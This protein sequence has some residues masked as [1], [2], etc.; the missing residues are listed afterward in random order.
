MED[1]MRAIILRSVPVV[2][3]LAVAAVAS[4]VTLTLEST[5]NG[6]VVGPN[7]PIDWT[8]KA[9]VS[10]GDNSGLA[11]ISVGLSQDPNNPVKFD[12]PPATGVPAGMTNFAR[13]A[14]ISNPGSA[15]PDFG[16]RGDQRGTTGAKNLVQIGGGQNTFG[17]A[18]SS[19]GTS[20]TVAQGVGQSAPQIIASGTFN[21]PATA[22]VYKYYLDSGL[23]NTLNAITPP[24]P[25][26]FWPVSAA[27]VV[28]PP[29]AA[30]TFTVA[31][32]PT[33]CPGDMNC[34]GSI[35]YGDINPFVLALNSQSAYEAAYPTCR[36]LNADCD[37]NG[38]VNYG[39]IN[40]F[41][42]KI[43]TACAK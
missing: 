29:T 2:F 36:W 40:P 24:V 18:G 7:T 34:D 20:V 1:N 4:T 25:P 3:A 41:V 23:A 13:A 6:G 27:T 12:I 17:T 10:T 26:A 15:A 37:N 28:G 16:Y 38:S 19:I 30:I 33:P 8:I 39:D 43:G 32:G 42:Q 21:A 31:I 22:G 5:K 9:S 35:N 14:G 11:L